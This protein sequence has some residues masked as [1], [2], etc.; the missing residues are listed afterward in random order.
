[1]EEARAAGVA[2][3]ID[4]ELPNEDELERELMHLE[5]EQEKLIAEL[6]KA[7]QDDMEAESSERRAALNEEMER[8]ARELNI[9]NNPKAEE[10]LNDLR[11]VN[12][13]F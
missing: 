10:Q 7:Y 11:N 2:D 13:F 4:L 12:I 1:M 5:R 9:L 8:K 3:I 6:R